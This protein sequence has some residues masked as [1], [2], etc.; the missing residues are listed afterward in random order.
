[1]VRVYLVFFPS[2]CLF[3]FIETNHNSMTLVGISNFLFIIDHHQHV[4]F[5]RFKRVA[6]NDIVKAFL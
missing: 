1:M 2:L 5:I 4:Y 6:V 3:V